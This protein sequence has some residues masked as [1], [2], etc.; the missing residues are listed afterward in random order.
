[1]SRHGCAAQAV[2]GDR[3]MRSTGVRFIAF[4]RKLAG[5]ATLDDLLWATAHQIA[6]ML[7]VHVVIL[8]PDEG[9]VVVRA[10]F[11]PEDSLDVADIAAAQ[12]VLGEEPCSRTRC[13]HVAWRQAA[14]HA[15]ADWPWCSSA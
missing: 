1:M 11:P 15:D 13:R 14:V 12:L 9:S 5:A 8:L 6:L 7:K 3:R 10:G 4:S 2:T